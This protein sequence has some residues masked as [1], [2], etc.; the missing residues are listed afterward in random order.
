MSITFIFYNLILFIIIPCPFLSLFYILFRVSW[1]SVPLLRLT[2]WKLVCHYKFNN[3]SIFLD[4]YRFRP[5]FVW[6][7]RMWWFRNTDLIEN[8]SRYIY[9]SRLFSSF[10][11]DFVFRKS[12]KYSLKMEHFSN[13]WSFS[14]ACHLLS[15]TWLRIWYIMTTDLAFC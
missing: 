2:R 14:L 15:P 7:G 9:F 12:S 8:L 4:V 11:T 3:H 1:L 13:F 5:I 6:W 10:K